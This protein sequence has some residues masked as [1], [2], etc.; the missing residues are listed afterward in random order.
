MAWPKARLLAGR[1]ASLTPRDLG[2]ELVDAGVPGVGPRDH[3]SAAVE[4]V[5]GRLLVDGVDG[6]D[7]K[8]GHPMLLASRPGDRWL[9]GLPGNSL[10]ACV[11]ML[12]LIEPLLTALHGR[13]PRLQATVRLAVIDPSG[14]EAGHEVGFLEFPWPQ[15]TVPGSH[16]NERIVEGE[17]HR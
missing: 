10:A 14:A 5:D 6:V 4:Q 13:Q 2:D 1:A 3:V 7:V 12:T 17:W 15:M 9:V 11:T 16:V 8:L